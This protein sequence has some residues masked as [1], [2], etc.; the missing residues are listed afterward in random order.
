MIVEDLRLV[1]PYLHV[2]FAREPWHVSFLTA[3]ALLE[4]LLHSSNEPRFYDHLRM[5]KHMCIE[6]RRV[7]EGTGELRTSRSV[8]AGEKLMMFLRVLT[9]ATTRDVGD[10]WQHSES[11]VCRA[12]YKV[13]TA[14]KTILPDC[15]FP[16]TSETP[17]K[18]SASSRFYPNFK[19]CVSELD[20]ELLAAMT[21]NL[22]QKY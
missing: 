8:L 19:D 2:N 10:R 17:T 9:G 6:L 20:G 13:A 5:R 12:V 11:T 4:E 1:A 3:A 7:S 16:P 22:L 15:M 18:M 21:H 14:V